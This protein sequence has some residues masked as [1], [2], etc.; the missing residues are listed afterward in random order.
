MALQESITNQIKVSLDIAK[1]LFLKQSDKNIVFSPVSLQVVFS[2]TAAGSEGP[3]QQQLVDFLSCST[4][5]H[6]I[7]FPSY[8]RTLLPLVKRNFNGILLRPMLLNIK[9]PKDRSTLFPPFNKKILFILAQS[10]L[11]VIMFF[12]IFQ[13]K[14]V[15]NIW[16]Y[17]LIYILKAVVNTHVWHKPFLFK[18]LFKFYSTKEK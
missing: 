17:E 7:L 16:R 11:I 18:C 4:P 14:A 9:W 3:T 2:L 5:S 13:L 6:L 8:S 1:H 12:H 15:V 10:K